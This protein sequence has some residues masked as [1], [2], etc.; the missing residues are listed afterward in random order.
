MNLKMYR[1]L[2]RTL[3]LGLAVAAAGLSST[4][5]RA[6]PAAAKPAPVDTSGQ[7]P[8]PHGRPRVPVRSFQ[9]VRGDIWRV[10]NGN[11]WSLVY[12]TPA[13]LLLVDP[14]TPDFAAWMKGQF[15]VRFPGKAV[16][17]I[18]YSH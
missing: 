12:D 3:V 5:L 4:A 9:Q 8:L 1:G 11:W 7:A 6:Q 13:G 15:A 16:R 10:S 2:R 17:Y 18:I 14:I